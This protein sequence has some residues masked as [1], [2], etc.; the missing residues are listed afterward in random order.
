MK[1]L[2]SIMLLLVG[3]AACNGTDEPVVVPPV[4]DPVEPPANVLRGCISWIDDDFIAFDWSNSELRPIY[5]ELHDFCMEH[6]IKPDIAR[7]TFSYPYDKLIPP[8]QLATCLQWQQDGF[9]FLYHPNHSMGWYNYSADSPHDASKIEESILDCFK[10]FDYYGFKAPKILVWPGNSAEYADNHPIVSRYYDCAVGAT[11]D[12]VNHLADNDR[13]NL[14]RLSFESLARGYHTKSSFKARIKEAIDRGDWVIFA[15]HFYDIEQND[16]PDET[17]YSTANVFEI[18][19]YADSLCHIR[20]TAEVWAE[21]KW[22][23]E[24]QGR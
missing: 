17:S 16:V 4:D 1:K 15:S 10:G 24:Q 19:Q 20:P 8:K 7:G 6:N 5:R 21:R 22:L 2:F 9:T 14:Q 11:Y 13:Y 23:W 18:L 3:L 12:R